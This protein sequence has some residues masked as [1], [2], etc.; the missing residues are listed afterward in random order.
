MA[1]NY[2]QLIDEL[3]GPSHGF[4][5]F[6]QMI[7]RRRGR[8]CFRRCAVSASG[9][10]GQRFSAVGTMSTLGGVCVGGV[11]HDANEPCLPIVW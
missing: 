9:E 10:S 11:E 5:W 6:N 2:Y 7:D 4:D 1:G 3:P 8:V